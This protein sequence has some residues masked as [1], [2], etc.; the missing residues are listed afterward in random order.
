MNIKNGRKSKKESKDF[1]SL[2]LDSNNSRSVFALFGLGH[3]YLRISSTKKRL[4]LFEKLS[5]LVQRKR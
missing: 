2:R 5:S 3:D 4:A 1:D